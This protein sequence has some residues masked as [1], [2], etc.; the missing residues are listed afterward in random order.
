[1]IRRIRRPLS[2]SLISLL[3]LTAA[4]C[5]QP[6][7]AQTQRP[8]PAPPRAHLRLEQITPAPQLPPETTTGPAEPVPQAQ[9]YLRTG[10]ERFDERL[11]ADATAALE[12]ALEIDPRLA[13]ARVLLARAAMQYGN[14]SLAES[15]LK[16]ALKD[17]PRD[18]AI[19]RLL[20]EVALQDRRFDE[21]I[22]AFRT[23]ILA[24]QSSS[25]N[26]EVA[27][28]HLSLALA[29]KEVGYFSAAAEELEAFAALT[30]QPTKEMREYHELNEAMLLYRAKLSV[31]IGELH[32]KLGA[33]DRAIAAYER[34]AAENPEDPNLR[35]RLA[36]A[37][38]RGGRTAEAVEQARKALTEKPDDASALD[39]LKEVCELSKAPERFDAELV[40]LARQAQSTEMRKR[41]ARL[42]LDRKKTA[43]ATEILTRVIEDSPDESEAAYLLA[44][45]HLDQKEFHSAVAIMA[46]ALRSHPSTYQDAV[47]L[48]SSFIARD[49]E[50]ALLTAL[51]NAVQEPEN[52]VLRYLVALIYWA[53]KDIPNSQQS[54]QESLRLD[55]DFGPAHVLLATIAAEQKRWEEAAQHAEDAIDNGL[56]DASVYLVKGT[57]LEALDKFQD[58]ETALLESFRLDRKSAEPLVRL[59]E[60]AERRGEVL[61]CEQIYRRIVDDVEPK[62]ER[63]REQLVRLYINSGKLQKAKEYF[64]DFERLGQ[65]GTAAARRCGSLMEFATSRELTGEARLKRYSEALGEIVKEY[66]RD[67]ETYIDLAMSYEAI[68][69]YEAALRQANAALAIAPEHPRAMKRKSDYQIKL[70]DFEGAAATTTALMTLRPRDPALL[71]RMAELAIARA[72]F[73]DAA[74]RLKALAARDDLKEGRELFVRRLLEVLFLDHRGDD[75]VEV[76]KGW[77]DLAPTDSARRGLYLAALQLAERRDEAVEAARKWLA[78]DPTNDDLRAQYIG[79]LIGAKRYVEGQQ[80]VLAWMASDADDPPLLRLLI[81]LFWAGRQWDSA[82]ELAQSAAEEVEQ[83]EAYEAMLGHTQ[84]LARRFDK[85]IEF[86]REQAGRLDSDLTLIDVLIDAERFTEAEDLALSRLAPA[87]PPRPDERGVDILALLA[88]R[89]SLV[90]IYQLMGREDQAAQQLEEILK[91]LPPDSG[92]PGAPFFDRFVGINNDLGYTWADAGR[93]MDEAE[94]MIRFA[95][96]EKPTT[97]AYVDSLG[98]VLYKRGQ[99]DEAIVHLR[100]AIRLSDSE[101][102]VLFD[103][104]ADALYRKG[105]VAEAREN[106]EKALKV[107]K[108]D[109]LS[110]PNAEDRRVL[111]GIREKLKA[112]DQE[113]E[114]PVAP[115]AKKEASSRPADRL[116]RPRADAPLTTSRPFKKPLPLSPRQ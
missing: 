71:Q 113:R 19:H 12:K 57:A 33:F 50:K 105:D 6:A 25:N 92:Q 39:L 45:L 17:R 80:R 5:Q 95:V 28:A 70:L 8:E 31:M 16:E 36:L 97:G 87:P 78:D 101:D 94:K 26:P 55:K 24:G 109:D 34:A 3:A 64:S 115:L 90:R 66:P 112:L 61:R 79:Q 46:G 37:L 30:A 58:A 73:V 27:L 22:A 15:H 74:Q 69:D 67:P 23:A 103:H 60:S 20:G 91:T 1:M 106:W 102:A 110:P 77:L 49:R 59:A 44:G 96:G 9:R 114:A 11:W 89:G 4:S 75:A 18:P 81:R 85:A 51:Q 76:A 35:K 47:T 82:I 88:V 48:I 62:H 116:P 42:L 63:A 32:E 107:H 10:Q 13:E 84:R 98:W 65:A 43:E 99:F 38:A 72:D 68:S 54:L 93:R 41:L 29:L 100:R 2:L 52:P 108:P 21:A 14:A 56:A 40:E 7:A 111:A 53:S 86:Y 83:R 104:L